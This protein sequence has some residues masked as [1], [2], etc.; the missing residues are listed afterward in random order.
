[1]DP[2]AVIGQG[3]ETAGALYT[4]SQNI[5]HANRM[6]DRSERLANSAHQR[7]VADLRAA[8]LNPILSA[9]GG[10]GAPS[11]TAAPPHLENPAAGA[12]ATG[13]GMSQRAQMADLL[14]SQEEKTKAE[15]LEVASRI[16]LNEANAVLAL[17]NAK[18]VGFGLKGDEARSKFWGAALTLAEG[19]LRDGKKL[20]PSFWAQQ[21]ADRVNAPM[22]AAKAAV[23]EVRRAAAAAG[24]SVQDFVERNVPGVRKSGEAPDPQGTSPLHPGVDTRRGMP[25]EKVRFE[26]GGGA[27][28]GG[29]NSGRRIFELQS[30]HGRR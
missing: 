7:E 15:S 30:S 17:E 28:H 27:E 13:S 11:P 26:H 8:G 4:N 23:E 1:M 29:P 19:I 9:T 10:N 25:R 24:Q 14:K 3:I 20:D 22:E 12:A 2:F 16:K 6:A 18:H 5:K 21:V